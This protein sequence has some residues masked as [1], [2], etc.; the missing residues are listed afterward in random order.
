MKLGFERVTMTLSDDT[1]KRIDKI[2]AKTGS[3]RAKFCAQIVENE[4]ESLEKIWGVLTDPEKAK[5]L[6]DIM[7]E[8]KGSAEK[9]VGVLHSSSQKEK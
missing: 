2:C 4:I 1:I 5:K 7:D 9:L 8:T 6:L 3:S